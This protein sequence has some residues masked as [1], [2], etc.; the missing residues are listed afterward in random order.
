MAIANLP[1]LNFSV[2]F[3]MTAALPV[4]YNAYFSTLSDATA[5]AATA[6]APGSSTTVYYYGQKIVVVGETEAKLY[7]I[8]PDKTLKEAGGVPLGDGASITVGEDGKIAI[9]GFAAAT[10]NQQPR[11]KVVDGVKTIEWYT[12]DNSTVAG[13]QQT[14]GQHTTE[15]DGLKTR[16][17]TA[18]GD[19]DALETWKTTASETIA[20]NTTLA[21][22]AKDAA[23]AAQETADK[24]VVANTEIT[25]GTHTK[26]TYDKKGLVTA[27]ADL[28]A[29]DIPEL[30]AAKITSGTFDVARI[31]DITL[32]KVSDAGTA[33]SKNVATSAIGTTATDDLVTGNQVKT[34]VTDAVAGLSGAMHF[35]G[36]STTDPKGTTGATVAGHTKWAAG[37]VVIFGNKE[38]VLD[39]AENKAANWH[40]LG[41]ETIYAV[42]GDIKNADIAADAAIDQSKINGLE[43]AL[44]AKATPADIDTK[45]TAHVTNN[46]NTLTIGTETYDGSEAVT[47]D[48]ATIGLGN[49]DN[50]ADANKSVASAAK[51]TTARTI[52]ISGAVT[53]TATS[54]DGSKNITI[55]ATAVDGTKVSGVVPEA[56]KA[57][58]DGAGEV[59]A[60]KYATKTELSDSITAAKD[61]L[62]VKFTGAGSQWTADKTFEEIQAAIAA[63]KIIVATSANSK[64]QIT[65]YDADDSHI[66]FLST[67]EITTEENAVLFPQ[68]KF[69]YSSTGS[70]SV[71]GVGTSTYSKAV[72]DEKLDG[73]NGKV[74]KVAGKG[75]SEADFTTAEKTKLDT[76]V[77][78]AEPNAISTVEETY[79]SIDGTKKLSLN[80]GSI[81]I[82][83]LD[84]STQES[85]RVGGGAITNLKDANNTALIPVYDSATH[86]RTVTLPGATASVLGM[87][88]GSTAN[89]GVAINADFTMTVNNITTDKLVQG[90]DTLIWNGGSAASAG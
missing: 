83:K 84:N 48:K 62:N 81:P 87:V 24:A 71:N 9:N 66:T 57:T 32:A 14:V 51:L 40:E 79:F 65:L 4:E 23:D 61:T 41:D 25:A 68:S 80:D 46:H 22:S 89:N 59:I 74:D 70:I 13:L 45:I 44:T 31:P 1:K 85:I 20:S 55:A 77:S 19:I 21:Q 43:D 72:L 58:Q 38:Y 12:P 3:A 29:A 27:G 67:E 15:I 54:F 2:P 6:E 64:G 17:G 88:K 18:E 47:V 39:K 90:T 78:G 73:E 30:G 35:V 50:T 63:G 28:T 11:V 52:G 7:I 34:Y 76:V 69:T 8:Q 26:I 42:K 49:V 36:V 56:T 53:G 37:D 16:M 10:A 82:G 5:A 86:T 75:L 60:D 33:A